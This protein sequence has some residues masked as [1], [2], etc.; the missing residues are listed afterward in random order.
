MPILLRWSKLA[1]QEGAEARLTAES[2]PAA[3]ASHLLGTWVIGARIIKVRDLLRQPWLPA[4]RE[5][6]WPHAT[7]QVLTAP[8]GRTQHA[9]QDKTMLV[10]KK[11]TDLKHR[12]Y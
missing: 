10:P 1:Q 2:L 6:W 12:S 3:E 8:V 7:G 5:G 9:G 4:K 11:S